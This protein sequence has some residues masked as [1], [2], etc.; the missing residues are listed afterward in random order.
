MIDSYLK[1]SAFTAVK[2]GAKLC[3]RGNICHRRNTKVVPSFFEKNV[4]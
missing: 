4:L 2:R 3:E 1:D